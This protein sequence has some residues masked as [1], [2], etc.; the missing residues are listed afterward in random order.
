MPKPNI[1]FS[2]SIRFFFYYSDFAFGISISEISQRNVQEIVWRVCEVKTYK[3][4]FSN[5]IALLLYCYAPK[6]AAHLQII[7]RLYS[8]LLEVRLQIAV[9]GYLAHLFWFS[10]YF[11]LGTT[12][13]MA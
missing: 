8:Y 11:L 9:L 7:L 5:V 1:P 2:K 4:L 6:H 12:V 13:E 3:S 10:K